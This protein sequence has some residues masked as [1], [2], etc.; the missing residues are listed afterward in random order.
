MDSQSHENKSC[1][2]LPFR[3]LFIIPGNQN[4]RDFSS[5]CCNCEGVEIEEVDYVP[6]DVNG[7]YI[8]RI[9]CPEN[10]WIEH[11]KD[12]QWWNM[13]MSSRKGFEGGEK[14]VHARITLCVPIQNAIELGQV[15]LQINSAFNKL[16]EIKFAVPVVCLLSKSVV[17]P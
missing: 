9:H 3:N 7:T 15:C 12:H 10:E 14:L 6:I 11:L 8:Y 17:M 4:R 16:V 5:I 13:H 2:W 1:W